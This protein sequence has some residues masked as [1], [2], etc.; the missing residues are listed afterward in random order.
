MNVTLSWA[1][2]FQGANA[3]VMR[4]LL[5]LKDG[6]RHA[7]GYSGGEGWE[8][9]ITGA[10]GELAFAKLTNRYWESVASDFRSLIGDVGRHQVRTTARENGCLIVHERDPDDAM[11]FLVIGTAPTFYVAGG[12]QGSAAKSE[13]WWRTDTGRPAFFV[14]QDALTPLEELIYS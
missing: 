10:L 1:E 8:L 5:N 6:N 7:H 14:P 4:H 13:E 11:F 12:I 2:V 9:H 3:G